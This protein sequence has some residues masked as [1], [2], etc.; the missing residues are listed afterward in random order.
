MKGSNPLWP[1][2]LG[3]SHRITPM[4]LKSRLRALNER[5]AIEVIIEIIS[6]VLCAKISF[7]LDNHI[8]HGLGEWAGF[9]LSLSKC[10]SAAL[11]VLV[12]LSCI[13]DITL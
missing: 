1:L 7:S 2:C 5:S 13:L 3:S 4:C 10:F 9:C 8:E 6:Q 12:L 11:S